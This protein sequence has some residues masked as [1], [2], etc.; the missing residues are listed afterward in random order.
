M[1][2]KKV[3]IKT[4]QQKAHAGEK[5]VM[6]TAYD[7]PTATI[8]EQVG[9]D[10]IIVGDSIGTTVYGFDSTLPVT[11][12]MMV[13]SCAA[14]RRGAPTMYTIGDMPYMS[15]Q[16]GA[17]DAIIN[18]GRLMAEGYVD[19]VKVEG[20]RN[21]LHTIEALVRAT[22]PVVGHLGLTPQSVAQLGGYSAQART[23]EAAASLVDQAYQLETAGICMLVLECVPPQVAAEVVSRVQIPVIGIG[24]GAA[25][26]GQVTIVHDM[27]GL[28]SRFSPKF[29]KQY[30]QL[31][32]QIARAMKHYSEQ[33]RTGEY[34]SD[35]HT[36]HMDD[37]QLKQFRELL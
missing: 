6:L 11:M 16:P 33:V 20:G 27:L 2:R 14:V 34:P 29:V 5:I 9:I 28:T 37:A 8:E 35:D 17:R 32:E 22:I 31:H 15:Y 26:H 30:A 25:C 36:Y 23:A 18:A 13:W 4:L 12:D 7:T 19:A 24:S 3:T 10:G 1:E 21:V